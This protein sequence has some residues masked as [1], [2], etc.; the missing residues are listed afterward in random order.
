M[1]GSMRKKSVFR[2]EREVPT[3]HLFCALRPFACNIGDET[4]IYMAL[5]DAKTGKYYRW[6]SFFLSSTLKIFMKSKIKSFWERE[7][8]ELYHRGCADW[9]PSKIPFGWFRFKSQLYYPFSF[10]WTY[11][12]QNE[13]E[14]LA[15]Q[16][17]KVVII[18]IHC[19]YLM[20]FDGFCW[21]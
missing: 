3:H 14:W 17:R 18:H 2:V 12:C 21:L 1:R 9:I 13:S 10:Q 8:K 6:I 19:K 20:P 5:Y 4:E 11:V 7:K 16:H 15:Y